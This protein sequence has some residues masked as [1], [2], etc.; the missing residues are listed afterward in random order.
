MHVRLYYE[1]IPRRTTTQGVIPIVFQS[2]FGVSAQG[3]V[4]VIYKG[5]ASLGGWGDLANM[6]GL[7]HNDLCCFL[8]VFGNVWDTELAP[9]WSQ[10]T[11]SACLWLVLRAEK[12]AFPVPPK[13]SFPVSMRIVGE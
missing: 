1:P 10:P 7:F 12:P 11:Q 6:A 3:E 8:H 13:P 2:S 5:Y 9:H 4:M